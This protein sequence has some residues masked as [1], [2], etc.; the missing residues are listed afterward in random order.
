VADS[1]Q[2]RTLRIEHVL[3]VGGELVDIRGQVAQLIVPNGL[4]PVIEVAATNV[5]GAGTDRTY[6]LEQPVNGR[7]AEQ[8]KREA[9]AD[10]DVAEVGAGSPR[11]SSIQA[12]GSSL[13]AGLGPKSSSDSRGKAGSDA[14]S[15]SG[16]RMRISTGTR[17]VIE[18]AR[19]IRGGLPISSRTYCTCSDRWPLMRPRMSSL[20]YTQRI[21][22]NVP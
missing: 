5:L 4:D 16:P 19:S 1:Q 14:Q 13:N 9:E 18:I 10:D 7:V 15:I 20:L 11:S 17:S 6:R 12:S 21:A 22:A 2:Q 8:Q 3:Y